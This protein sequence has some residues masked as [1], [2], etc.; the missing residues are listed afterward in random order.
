MSNRGA[1]AAVLAELSKDSIVVGHLL[2]IQLASG[3]IR[4]TDLYKDTTFDTNTFQA[5][6]HLLN[7][8]AVEET[9]NIE[10]NE[11][12]ISF[13]GVDPAFVSLIMS[14][15][16][17]DRK[18]IIYKAFLSNTDESL[19]IDPLLIFEGLINSVSLSEDPGAGTATLDFSVTNQWVVFEKVSNRRTNDS[20]QQSLYPGDLGFQFTSE[21]VRDIQWGRSA[22]AQGEAAARAESYYRDHN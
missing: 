22:E 12:G 17:V 14:E 8:D 18:V 13:S 3:T 19:I 11:V 9:I 2:E 21:L 20:Q 10:T 5:V 1:T 4:F 16:Y 6:G 15:T 7:I